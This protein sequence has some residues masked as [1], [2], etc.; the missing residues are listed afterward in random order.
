MRYK[1]IHGVVVSVHKLYIAEPRLSSNHSIFKYGPGGTLT[2]PKSSWFIRIIDDDGRKYFINM[3]GHKTIGHIEE[4]DEISIPN[5]R[6]SNHFFF[7]FKI[8]NK[9]DDGKKFSLK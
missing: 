5:A 1:K 6:I 8:I 3:K 9:Y 4:G 7:F 2:S